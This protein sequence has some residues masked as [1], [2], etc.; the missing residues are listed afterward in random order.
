MDDVLKSGYYESLVTYDNLDWFVDETINLENKMVLYFKN[1]NKGNI[2]TEND[3]E[4][5]RNNNICRL[6]EKERTVDKLRDPC[7][8]TGKSRGPAHQNCNINVAWK[9]AIWVHFYFT[10][11]II[12]TVIYFFEKLVVKKNDKVKFDIIPKTNEEH[13][14]VKNGCRRFFKTY[15]FLSKFLDDLVKT[16]DD[17]CF[18]KYKN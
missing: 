9:K 16:F 3:E 11:L 18:E 14:S 12:R 6:C 15:R 7:Q 17:N 10:H 4:I 8:I 5:Y 1:T 13:I 2:M